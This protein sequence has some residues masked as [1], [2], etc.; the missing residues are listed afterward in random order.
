MIDLRCLSGCHCL[1]IAAYSI[2]DR[3]FIITRI[4]SMYSYSSVS[5]LWVYTLSLL[6]H[7]MRYWHFISWNGDISFSWRKR[8][9]FIYTKFLVLLCTAI[10]LRKTAFASSQDK[11]QI[12]QNWR[13]N[14]IGQNLNKKFNIFNREKTSGPHVYKIKWLYHHL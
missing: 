5:I 4:Y 14:R 9:T 12:G 7:W 8:L 1:F 10:S 6:I 2:H 13:L 3:I 11:A